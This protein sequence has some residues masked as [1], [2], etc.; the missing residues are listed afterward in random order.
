MYDCFEEKVALITGGA[1]GMCFDIAKLLL[2]E[3]AH[4]VIVDQD[5]ELLE[6]AK[7]ELSENL[8]EGQSLIAIAADVSHSGNV[9]KLVGEVL[10]ELKLVDVLINGAGIYRG[11]SIEETSDEELDELM[12]TNLKA[13]FY[14]CRE[15]VPQMA[16]QKGGSIVNISSIGGVV[17]LEGSAAYVASKTALVGLTRALALDLAPQG[18]RVNGIAPGWTKTPMTES[19]YDDPNIRTAL[20][21]DT[22]I[23]RF[24][25]SSEQ[26]KLAVWLASDQASYMTG[27]TI[28]NDGG[29]TLR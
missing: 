18:I 6:K 7:K 11:H 10:Q 27:Q 8:A 13:P 17:A 21:A 16:K 4:V 9:K 22:P 15:V 28:L 25:N 12:N 3:K 20:L 19:L 29:W 26:A 5:A 14:L 1:S 23:N 24:A 2:N